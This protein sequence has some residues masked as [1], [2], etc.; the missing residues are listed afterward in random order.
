M[1]IKIEQLIPISNT[2]EYKLHAARWNNEEQPLDVFLESRERWHQW[3]MWRNDKDEFSR[4]YIF[5]LIDFYP[6]NDMWL[7]GGIFEIVERTNEPQA[8]SYKIKEDEK[9]KG[10]VGRLKI[11]MEKPSR[12]RA[13]YLENHY[14]KMEVFEIL[15][16][17]YAGIDFPGYDN[18]DCDFSQLVAIINSQKGDWKGALQNV[19]GIYMIMDKA[20]GKKYIGSAYGEYGVWA[21][22]SN[23]IYS[24]HGNNDELVRLIMEKGMDYAKENFKFVLLEVRSMKTDD[25]EI[26]NRETYWKNALLSRGEYG[27][28]KN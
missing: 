10:L 15:R 2:K 1:S 13:F 12:G 7:F 18:I 17:E 26:I 24:G 28:N 11:R 3:N 5:S 22:W 21:R 8:L 23:Y 27:Y 19:K 4:K 16:E 9:Y 6:E 20:N 14:N 25:D